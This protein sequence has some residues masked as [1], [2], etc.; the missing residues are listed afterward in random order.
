MVLMT[1]IQRKNQAS[2]HQLPARPN[3]TVIIPARNQQL[4]KA[5]KY[6]MTAAFKRR[7][8]MIKPDCYCQE[9]QKLKKISDIFVSG[10]YLHAFNT[11]QRC[12]G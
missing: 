3:I 5:D 4:R 10:H 11:T 9:R 1:T 8:L 7:L 2:D 6:R 12:R